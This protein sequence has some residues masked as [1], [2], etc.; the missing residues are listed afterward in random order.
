[1]YWLL[2]LGAAAFGGVLL[3]KRR[4]RTVFVSY[5]HPEQ[6]NYRSLLMAWDAHEGIDFKFAL[7]SP[8]ETIPGSDDEV[9]RELK[10]RMKDSDCLLI[11]VGPETCGRPWVEWEVATAVD[12]G[13]PLVAVKL[14]KFHEGPSSLYGNEAIWVY[15]FEQKKI[16]KALRET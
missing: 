6:A 2:G 16:V 5:C 7:G 3:Y 10:R 9:R 13:I 15:G 14:E 8:T 12:L 11:L 1:M 4:R